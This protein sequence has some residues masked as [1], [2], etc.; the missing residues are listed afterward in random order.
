MVLQILIIIGFILYIVFN[1]INMM[2]QY[3]E[4]AKAHFRS[5]RNWKIG[6]SIFI[7][8]VLYFAGTF[9]LILPKL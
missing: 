9:D 4:E 7:F 1:S 8:I 5:D 3:S 2:E 6:T